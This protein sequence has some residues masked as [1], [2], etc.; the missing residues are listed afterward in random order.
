MEIREMTDRQHLT[1]LQGRIEAK[2]DLMSV[3]SNEHIMDEIDHDV[4]ELVIWLD[5]LIEDEMPIIVD[6]LGAEDVI[7]DI[8][9]A[10]IVNAKP[11]TKAKKE[12]AL[13]ASRK[14][15]LRSPSA[16]S[17][18]APADKTVNP[19]LKNPPAKPKKNKLKKKGQG[20]K[21]IIVTVAEI[22]KKVTPDDYD[23]IPDL[24]RAIVEKCTT[25]SA[26][27]RLL[28]IDPAAI[29]TA[30]NKNKT[31]PYVEKAFRQ[32]FQFPL[33]VEANN[34]ITESQARAANLGLQ[35]GQKEPS[36]LDEIT[37]RFTL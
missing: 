37:K 12:A 15:S 18:S 27:A 23:N 24:T 32:I 1:Y 17:K 30:I 9:L 3:P 22:L 2:L 10:S 5:G 33:R 21:P 19:N 25:K 35:A 28:E 29:A 4:N 11:T 34:D 7:P 26:L 13:A 8:T 6:C 14:S 20:R 16:N 31:Y 36:A